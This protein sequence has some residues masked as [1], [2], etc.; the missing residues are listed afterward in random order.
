MHTCMLHLLAVGSV[1]RMPSDITGVR[2]MFA[3]THMLALQ[4]K[5]WL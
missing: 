5:H 4:N 1:I 2:D 3:V